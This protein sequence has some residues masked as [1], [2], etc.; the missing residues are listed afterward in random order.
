[1]EPRESYYRNEESNRDLNGS[2]DHLHGPD[3]LH[4]VNVG[5][6]TESFEKHPTFYQI[7]IVPISIS[8]IETEG[9]MTQRLERSYEGVSRHLLSRR[10]FLDDAGRFTGAAALGGIMAPFWCRCAR[11]EFLPDPNA[12]VET[13]ASGVA[14]D[15]TKNND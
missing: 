7:G 8:S 4:P 10:R 14:M 9:T 5:C 15:V 3:T 1:M 12:V 6:S 13:T 11:A 2:D